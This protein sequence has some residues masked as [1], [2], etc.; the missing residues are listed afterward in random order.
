MGSSVGKIIDLIK[1]AR[2][3]EPQFKTDGMFTVVLK[4]RVKSSGK[5]RLLLLEK[6]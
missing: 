2:L 1:E 4:R 3:P 6:K 5:V